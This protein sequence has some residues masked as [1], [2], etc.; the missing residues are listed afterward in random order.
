MS[1]RGGGKTWCFY[2]LTFCNFPFD[3]N[4]T[5]VQIRNSRAFAYGGNF[6]EFLARPAI[7][8]KL[9]KKP[10]L[11]G[12]KNAL[13]TPKSGSNVVGQVQK[14]VT[15]L[16]R[17]KEITRF[18]S[19]SAFQLCN[20]TLTEKS[21]T[22]TNDFQRN[23][24]YVI[25]L[26]HIQNRF[27]HTV[28]LQQP[29]LCVPTLPTFP[30]GCQQGVEERPGVYIL[31]FCNLPFDANGTRVQ[32]QNLHAF[33]CGG[34]FMSFFARAHEEVNKMVLHYL[35]NC[36]AI[37][38]WRPSILTIPGMSA[39]GWKKDLVFTYS[40]F[41]TFLLMLMEPECKFRKYYAFA[42]GGNLYEFLASTSFTPQF[43]Q[44]YV[45][46]FSTA[47]DFITGKV[48]I[49]SCHKVTFCPEK[50]PRFFSRSAFQLCN[51]TLTEKISHPNQRHPK[52]ISLTLLT[53]PPGCQQGWKEDLMFYILTSSHLPFDANGTRVQIQKP[54]CFRIYRL[55]NKNKRRHILYF[56]ICRLDPFS[57]PRIQAAE[58]RSDS[59]IPC[60]REE[61]GFG[62]ERLI[63]AVKVPRRTFFP[64]CL[65]ETYFEGTLYPTLLDDGYDVKLGCDFC[66]GPKFVF[67]PYSIYWL[68]TSQRRNIL[69]FPI[70]RPDPFSGPRIQAAEIRSDSTI[71]CSRE[72]KGVGK[73]G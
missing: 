20:S 70:C 37:N 66:I 16:P 43:P 34:N 60:S 59:T 73:E 61:K 4:G 23:K 17:P 67:L 71:S 25:K 11:D 29:F 41:A 50:I 5:R 46:K 26:L 15:S 2:I 68:N 33:A 44:Y 22:Q 28:V 18:F 12:E 47:S 57:G 6:Y 7:F 51:S 24:S 65:W 38:F 53:I 49:L 19:R 3:A 8:R 21:A 35:Y 9:E 69:D 72:E 62:K 31:T 36:W 56:P 32:I 45:K 52:G 13:K 64:L 42:Y 14:R 58:I 10:T 54:A 27:E 40:H 1:A 55:Q 48:K 63:I 39:K 30:Q